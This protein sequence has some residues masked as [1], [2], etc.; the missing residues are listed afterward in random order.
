MSKSSGGKLKRRDV[1]DYLA[2]RHSAQGSSE[3][4]QP[5]RRHTKTAHLF[6]GAASLTRCFGNLRM[7]H[8]VRGSKKT[9][10]RKSDARNKKRHRTGVMNAGDSAIRESQRDSVLKPRVARRLRG[11]SYPGSPPANNFQPER[12]CGH[13]PQLWRCPSSSIPR[14]PRRTFPPATGQPG[15]RSPEA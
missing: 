10:C 5:M 3:I 2:A 7:K 8:S 4:F 1:L 9:I 13:S 12:G 14:N 15:T 6:V 11:T